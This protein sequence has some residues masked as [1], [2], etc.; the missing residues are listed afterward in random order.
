MFVGSVSGQAENALNLYTS[1]FDNSD[2]PF[3]TRYG[4]DA[5][6]EQEGTVQYASFS[7]EGQEFGAMDSALEH[8]FSFNEAVSFIVNCQD[9]EEV[10][11]FWENLTAN[12]GEESMCGWL[13]DPFGVSW[14]IIP[15]RLYELIG[16]EDQEKSGRA[17]EAMLQMKKIDIASLEEAYN[18]WEPQPKPGHHWAVYQNLS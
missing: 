18:G 3:L 12:G 2:V 6:P 9:Q 7:L 10:D 11:Y 13:K 14:Q 16:S 5:E 1:L 4:K 17:T 8:N 15:R